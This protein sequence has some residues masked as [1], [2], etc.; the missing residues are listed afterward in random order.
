MAEI[1]RCAKSG[2]DWTTNEL[3]A[4]NITVEY[5]DVA[6]FFGAHDLPQPATIN[7]AVLTTTSPDDAVDTGV[8]EI[9][10]TMDLAMAPAPAEE[11]AIDGFAVLL[12]RALG[13]TTRGRVLRSRKDIPLIICGENRLAKTDVCVVDQNE[14]LLLVQEDKRHLEN[15]D[16]EPQLIAEAI[17]AFAA[18]N[19]ARQ[20]TLRQ[21][22]L[23]SKVMAGITMQG[24]APIFCKI[25]AATTLVACVAGGLYPQ[26]V[27][28]V[29]AHIP[30][31]PRPNRRW[32]E[33]VKPLEN[34]EVILPCFE[35]FKLLVN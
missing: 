32:S 6:T 27:T 33:A 4:Y 9:L 20:K 19:R 10:R 16:P 15:S 30:S 31:I 22:P 17:A 13:H 29:Y 7:P 3:A 11:S 8:Y 35:S 25:K 12:L 5:Q 1:I 18:N 23:D 14:I 2:S 21:P 26:A 24:T 28:T 34:R